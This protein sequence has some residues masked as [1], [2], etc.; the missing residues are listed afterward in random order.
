M[1]NMSSSLPYT[2]LKRS[3]ALT[4]ETYTLYVVRPAWTAG[5]DSTT[6]P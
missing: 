3:V 6:N 5:L 2:E 4:M 1:L